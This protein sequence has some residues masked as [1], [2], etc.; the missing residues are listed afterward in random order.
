MRTNNVSRA[1]T[2]PMTEAMETGSE[3]GGDF[4]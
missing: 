2:T 1:M 4:F 3:I